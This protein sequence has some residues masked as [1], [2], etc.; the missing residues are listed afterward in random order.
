MSDDLVER[1]RQIA[2]GLICAAAEESPLG[3]QLKMRN[4]E[5]ISQAAAEI[6]R[7]RA[8]VEAARSDARLAVALAYQRVATKIGEFE[9][10]ARECGE[11]SREA[12]FCLC[13]DESLALADSDDLAEVQTLR[14]ERDALME[15]VQANM[16][17]PDYLRAGAAEATVARLR[18]ALGILFAAKENS[19]VWGPEI[20]DPEM[21]EAWEK[22]AAINRT[23]QGDAE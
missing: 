15:A 10:S 2:G 7:L 9:A 20:G 3:K 13:V 11:L 16:L 14:A 8:K 1:L 23:A 21:A 19:D 22:A 17:R 4:A 18:E 12:A 6:T 5:A